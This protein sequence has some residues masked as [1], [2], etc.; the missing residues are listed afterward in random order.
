MLSYSNFTFIEIKILIGLLD[1]KSIGGENKSKF[2]TSYFFRGI[3]CNINKI[4]LLVPCNCPTYS[5]IIANESD[6]LQSRVIKLFFF[7]FVALHKK[8]KAKKPRKEKKICFLGSLI[9]TCCHTVLWVRGRM[10]DTETLPSST[11]VD[12][13]W[14]QIIVFES[15][16]ICDF[17]TLMI[18]TI[19]YS[20][21]SFS[22]VTSSTTSIDIVNH[23]SECCLIL[24]SAVLW[25]FWSSECKSL[26][27]VASI[28]SWS[29]RHHLVL[30][31]H[32]KLSAI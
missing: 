3:N 2:V 16:S 14:K 9:M 28:T 1:F 11:P 6:W 10:E 30:V 21:I 29:D 7:L 8:S 20:I 17:H 18:F 19:D 5:L 31:K 4:A 27:N 15:W 23:F 22:S 13:I 25:E 24:D 12:N 32:P 26:R